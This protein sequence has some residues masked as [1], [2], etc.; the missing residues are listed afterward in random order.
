MFTLLQEQRIKSHAFG[1]NRMTSDQLNGLF[2]ASLAMTVFVV[3]A[4]LG[5]TRA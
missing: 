4:L 3:V 2:M 1:G 5:K